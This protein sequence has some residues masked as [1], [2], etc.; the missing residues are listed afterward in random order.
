MGSLTMFGA[1]EMQVLLRS[2]NMLGIGLVALWV[3][4]PLGGQASLR[5]LD[6]GVQSTQSNQDLRYLN[7]DS[8]S[9]LGEGE[10]TWQGFGFLTN[11]LY[12]AA[13]LTPSARQVAPMDAWGNIRIPVIET[14]EQAGPADGEGWLEV[15]LKNA[16]YSSLLGLPIAGIPTRGLSA[17]KM[18]SYY[19]VVSFRS[20]S[21]S[22]DHVTATGGFVSNLTKPNSNPFEDGP[23]LPSQELEGPVEPLAV[24]FAAGSK[25]T[26]QAFTA[27]GTLTR[28]SLESKV[29]CEGVSCR[30][31]HVRRSTFDRRPAAYTPLSY[32]IGAS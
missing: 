26:D 7:S 17:F 1:M 30:V 16:S 3:L 13:L 31:T 15:P 19:F 24:S 6:K 32:G 2:F 4:S 25:E 22:E 20:V 14:L 12:L 27:P 29:A 21:S 10:D 8:R 5:L 28:S 11:S 9:L 23:L 18:D